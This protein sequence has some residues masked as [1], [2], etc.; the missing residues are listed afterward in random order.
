M[1]KGKIVLVMWD[2]MPQHELWSRRYD[3]RV[4]YSH[5]VLAF[6][7]MDVYLMNIDL[8][9][10]LV[11]TVPALQVGGRAAQGLGKQAPVWEGG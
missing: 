11:T 4:V 6:T 10:Y 5:A 3:Q 2:S 9:E 7:G 1:Q 8:D